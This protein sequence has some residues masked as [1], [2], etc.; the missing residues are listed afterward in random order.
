ML[1][2]VLLGAA[3]VSAAVGD[4]KDPIVILVVLP[5]NAVFGFIQEYRA[6]AAMAALASMLEMVV[7]VRRGGELRE[8]PASEIVPGD[9]VVLEAGDR[10]PADGRFVS[11]QQPGGRRG[12]ADRRVGAVGQAHGHPRPRAGR[13][14]R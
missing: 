6:D 4:L 13:G 9:V 10:V 5:I 1:V 11:G 8:M 7:R 2:Y 3:V 12:R 14:D